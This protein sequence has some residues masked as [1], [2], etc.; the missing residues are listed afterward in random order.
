MHLPFANLS[1]KSQSDSFDAHR[2]KTLC[3]KSVQKAL[4]YLLTTSGP[5]GFQLQFT[6]VPSF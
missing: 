6:I 5:H 2:V 4:T 1:A 3:L